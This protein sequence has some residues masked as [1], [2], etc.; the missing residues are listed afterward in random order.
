MEA[1]ACGLP[2]I[3]SNEGGPKESVVD[4]VTGRIITSDDPAD[5]CSAIEALLADEPRRQ[6]LSQSAAQRG[7]R[8]SL[9]RTFDYFWAEHL[10]AVQPPVSGA[11]S[12]IPPESPVSVTLGDFNGGPSKG[13]PSK[14]P[15]SL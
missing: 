15:A 3:V 14:L 4:Y 5:W 8:F 12:P 6:R 11:S 9:A 13:T 2:A 1:Q 7:S 10:A